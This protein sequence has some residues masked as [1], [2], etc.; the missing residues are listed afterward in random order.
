[1]NPRQPRRSLAK[2]LS[3]AAAD[4]QTTHVIPHC[5]EC[6]KPCCSLEALVLEMEWKQVK[7]LWSIEVQKAEFDKQLA[8]GKG[9]QEIRAANGLYYIHSKPCP[10]FDQGRGSCR[11]YNQP[12]KPVGCSDFPVYEDDGC[13]VADLRCEAVDLNALTTS[14][15]RAVGPEFRVVQSADKEFPFLVTLLVKKASAR[16]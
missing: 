3:A 9:P 15:A 5:P 2:E 8:A 10:A 1:M 6:T 7:T 13:V 12:V 14:I 16:R 4:Y 11:V